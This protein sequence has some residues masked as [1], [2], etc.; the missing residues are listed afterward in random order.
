M[1]AGE[2]SPAR[3]FV[4]RGI[5]LSREIGASTNYTKP[6][7]TVPDRFMARD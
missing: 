2:Q 3:L 4:I 6:H 5:L 7:E 1:P